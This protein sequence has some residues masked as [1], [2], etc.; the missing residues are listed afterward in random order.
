MPVVLVCVRA[1]HHDPQKACM[2]GWE[3]RRLELSG[4]EPA[5]LIAG[6]GERAQRLPGAL[7]HI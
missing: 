2:L 5:L 6:I 1:V 3:G 4:L 7:A